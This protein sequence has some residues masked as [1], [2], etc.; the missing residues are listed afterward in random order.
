MKKIK[1]RKPLDLLLFFILGIG[2]GVA[3]GMSSAL[4]IRQ[5]SMEKKKEYRYETTPLASCEKEKMYYSMNDKDIYLYC[6][7]TIKVHDD[8]NLLE[9]KNYL[10]NHP[11]ELDEIIKK[12]KIVEEYEDGGSI[13][14]QDDGK[15]S[16]NGFAILKCS[17]L[18]GSRD[19]YIGPKDMKFETRFCQ[20]E[21]SSQKEQKTFRRT[22]HV[23]NVIE[24]DEEEYLYVTVRM[25]Q[26][27]EVATVKIPSKLLPTIQANK[28]YEF[29]FGYIEPVE[30]TIVSI[31]KNTTL[32]SIHETGKVGLEQI[33]E[34]ME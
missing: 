29:Q 27:E 30:D 21:E 6:L 20:V 19:I 25:F 17:T 24:S 10:P 1:S 22:Y 9:L 16:E 7:N 28:N 3:F 34:S 11:N 32:L 8:N 26:D 13:L 18:D 2:V 31:F 15:L 12:M 5:N 4:L 33:Q 14:Y 23:L